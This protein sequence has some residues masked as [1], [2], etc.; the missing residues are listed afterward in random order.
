MR[1]HLDT[2]PAPTYDQVLGGPFMF[3]ITDATEYDWGIQCKCTAV[4]G[5]FEGRIV[6]HG[7]GTHENSK[8]Y[9][10]QFL[11]ACGVMTEDEEEIDVEPHELENCQFYAKAKKDKR[12]PDEY[13]TLFNFE[14]VDKAEK[15]HP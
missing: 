9:V 8:P 10:K 11:V 6:T 15:V 7:I 13:S 12:S 3:T 4:S 1:F 5:K 14:S 2:E